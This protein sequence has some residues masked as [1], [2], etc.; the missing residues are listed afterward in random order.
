MVAPVSAGAWSGRCVHPGKGGH[1]HVTGYTFVC[2]A[3]SL[4]VRVAT[5]SL[6]FSRDRA[7]HASFAFSCL[8]L[9]AAARGVAGDAVDLSCLGAGAHEPRSIGYSSHPGH[10]IR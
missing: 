7:C 3:V 2:R 5:G 9:V 8:E 1:G 10:A 6:T 4:V